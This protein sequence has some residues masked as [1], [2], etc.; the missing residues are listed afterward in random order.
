MPHCAFDSLSG[1]RR[2]NLVHNQS[3]QPLCSRFH[4]DDK[5]KR[6][7]WIFLLVTLVPTLLSANTKKM[8]VGELQDVLT[9][10]HN[11]QKSD[12]QIA[13]ELKQIELT[14][15]LT[16][17]GMNSMVNLINGPLSTEQ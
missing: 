13:N 15:E 2:D 8:T 7:A 12:E 16:S 9:G 6:L 11:S 3:L 17:A 4:P 5:M 1:A 10:L 14:E